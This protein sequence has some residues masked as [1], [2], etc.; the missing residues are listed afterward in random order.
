MSSNFRDDVKWVR[1]THSLS[2]DV[3]YESVRRVRS[4]G[5]TNSLVVLPSSEYLN[6][7]L[8]QNRREIEELGCEVPLV[9]ASLY[10]KMTQKRSALM[11]FSRSEERR[12]GNECVSTC[13]SGWSPFH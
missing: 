8:L 1:T 7:F 5:E 2:L 11:F 3:F 4:G 6:T 9:D 10:M 13:R 12:V